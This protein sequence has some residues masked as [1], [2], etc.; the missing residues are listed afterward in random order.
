MGKHI[1]GAV[2]SFGV[3][4]AGLWLMQ[5][6]FAFGYQPGGAGWLGATKND[7]WVGLVIAV[8]A[9]VGVLLFAMS[10]LAELR[11]LGVI[12]RRVVPQATAPAA[13][14]TPAPTSQ[15]DFERVILPMATALLADM[16]ERRGITPPSNST[17]TAA[18]Y[19]RPE[20][21]GR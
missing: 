2:A 11:R 5:A 14:P 18:A 13:P 15:T 6:P 16:A 21:E 7:F 1:L 17:A 12:E 3:M 9:L 8:V 20:G 4:V 19:R 10:L